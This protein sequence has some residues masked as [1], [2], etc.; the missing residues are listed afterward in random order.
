M[1]KASGELAGIREIT[2]EQAKELVYQ[3]IHEI[4]DAFQNMDDIL[5]EINRKNTQYQKAAINRA[6]FYLIGGEDVRGQLKEI[7]SEVNEKINTEGMELGAI[8]RISFLDELI[9]IYSSGILDE[10]SLYVPIEGKKEFKPAGLIND[11]PDEKVRQEKLKK[12]MEKME[13]VLN[14]PKIDR[15]VQDCLNGRSR[16]KASQMPLETIEDFVRIIYVRLYGQRKNMQYEIEADEDITV[17]GYRFRDY[18]I[19]KKEPEN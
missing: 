8:Y 2:I 12:M 7:L 6:K 15:Y 4:I 17:N 3:Y 10:K 11:F 14:P 19:R 16:M 18:V 13:R 5:A 9:K 1:E